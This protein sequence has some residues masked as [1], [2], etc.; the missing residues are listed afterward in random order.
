MAGVDVEERGSD[1][2]LATA[3]SATIR[4]TSTDARRLRGRSLTTMAGA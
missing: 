3:M 2:V 4:C 1:R